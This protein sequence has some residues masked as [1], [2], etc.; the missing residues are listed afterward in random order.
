MHPFP[1]TAIAM[2][3]NLCYTPVNLP[4]TTLKPELTQKYTASIL[5]YFVVSWMGLS[6]QQSGAIALAAQ[7]TALES[8]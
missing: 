1:S 8:V 4:Y 6:E 2:A 3:F 7:G 5:V